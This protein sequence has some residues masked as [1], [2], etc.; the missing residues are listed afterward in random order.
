MLRLVVCCLYS[1]SYLVR[2]PWL[3]GVW[4][5]DTVH[6]GP[7]CNAQ[8]GLVW[9]RHIFALLADISARLGAGSFLSGGHEIGVRFRAL[10]SL[11]KSNF[12]ALSRDGKC[13]VS[14]GCAGITSM[15]ADTCPLFVR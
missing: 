14:M 6:P 10:C 3:L 13:L 9:G 7:F 2:A 1:P 15:V 5:P 12:C 11:K 4:P 8:P